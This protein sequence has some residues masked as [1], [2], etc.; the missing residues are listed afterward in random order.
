MTIW[1]GLVG[2]STDIAEVVSFL[3]GPA[4]WGNGQVVYADGGVV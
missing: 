4:R 2:M 1:G 3:A